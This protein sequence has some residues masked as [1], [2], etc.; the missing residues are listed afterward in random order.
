[1]QYNKDIVEN[2]KLDLSRVEDEIRRIESELESARG[3]RKSIL[4]ELAK[5][6][7]EKYEEDML[8]RVYDQRRKK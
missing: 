7:D 3:R 8:Q 1:M 5:Y 4:D 2:L 6:S